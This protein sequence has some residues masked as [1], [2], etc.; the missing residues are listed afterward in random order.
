M[1]R[2]RHRSPAKNCY[3]ITCENARAAA[4]AKMYPSDFKRQP[5]VVNEERMGGVKAD[6]GKPCVDL[7]PFDALEEVG[8]VL[9]YGKRKYAARNWEL[10]MSWGRMLGACLR[11]LFAWARGVEVDA[12][13]GLHHLSHAACC[14][15]MLLALVL[16][17][18][19]TD[20]RAV[21]P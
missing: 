5:V 20:D 4:L 16:R 21:A 3:C 14:A 18:V 7:L 15:L 6:A 19:G 2:D 10:G 17:K 1:K 12:E 9:E 11:H 13:S 8:K